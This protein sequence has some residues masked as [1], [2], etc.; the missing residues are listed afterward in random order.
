MEPQPNVCPSLGEM[1]HTLSTVLN[2]QCTNSVTVQTTYM[3]T[4]RVTITVY[5]SIPIYTLMTVCP[6]ST[7]S[8]TSQTIE[9][10]N[11]FSSA[12][13]TNVTS[14]PSPTH[15]TTSQICSATSTVNRA[16]IPA[17]GATVG[18]LVAL[19][20]VVTM[21]WVY[22]CKRKVE[23]GLK[24]QNIRYVI[25]LIYWSCASNIIMLLQNQQCNKHE[26]QQ[27]PSICN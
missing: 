19:L 18:L 27:Q 9:T 26:S 15:S 3:C 8:L 6:S 10:T 24:P 1:V 7:T 12:F 5:S 13:F 14:Y 4:K 11:V 20:I 25:T 16:T 17:T 22:T 23:L 2:N 21:G